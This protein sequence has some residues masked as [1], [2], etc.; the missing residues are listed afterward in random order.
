M[1][2]TLK[3]LALFLAAAL[4]SSFAAELA[5]AHLPAALDA[6]NVFLAFVSTLVV[7][8]MLSEYS[9]A[10]RLTRTAV[11]AALPQAEHPLAA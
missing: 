2:T 4:P 5:G 7:L 10:P 11:A 8:T 3:V 1:K 6:G 9:P